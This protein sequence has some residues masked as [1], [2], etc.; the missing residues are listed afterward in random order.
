M[1]LKT[2][3]LLGAAALACSSA[4]ADIIIGN[5]GAGVGTGTIFGVGAS[6]IYK[7]AGFTMPS[8]DYTLDRVTL[9][10][11]FGGG[12]DGTVEIWT[13]STIPQTMVLLLDSPAQTGAGDFTFTPPQPFTLEA[14]ETYWVYVRARTGTPGSFLWDGTSPSTL[15]SGIARHVNYIFNGNPSSFNNRFQVEGTP[16]GGCYADCD[17]NS[18]LD[19]FDF[20][21]FQ[22]AFVGMDP[23]A[24]CDGNTTFDVFDFLCFQDEFVMG[25]P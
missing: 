13:G 16:V 17:G 6:T 20:L 15:P 3:V 9:T 19:V 1:R 2:G 10:M 11:N 12:G 18:V 22:D 8:Q 25:C 23:Y 14:D 24:D 5:F 21:C 4:Q 7:A